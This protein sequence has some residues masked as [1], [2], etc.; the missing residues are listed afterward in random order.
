MIVDLRPRN[1]TS[2]SFKRL[3]SPHDSEDCKCDAAPVEELAV[4]HYSLTLKDFALK[5]RR[6]W[7]VSVIPTRDE[8]CKL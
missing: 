3:T 5:T 7:G 8:E 1:E 2:G 4:L 6:Y